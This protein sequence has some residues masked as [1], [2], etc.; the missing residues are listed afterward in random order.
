MGKV[1]E[2]RNRHLGQNHDPGINNNRKKRVFFDSGR[3]IQI[4]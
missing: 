2:A 1:F 4:E 3:D